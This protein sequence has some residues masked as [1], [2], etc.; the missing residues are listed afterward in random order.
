MITFF[1]EY[2]IPAFSTGWGSHGV[3]HANDE[4]VEIKNLHNGARVLEAFVKEYDGRV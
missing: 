4:Y 2:G 1:Q 3:I